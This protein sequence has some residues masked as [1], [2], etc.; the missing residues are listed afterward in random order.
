[1]TSRTFPPEASVDSRIGYDTATARDP[2]TLEYVAVTI[3]SIVVPSDSVAVAVNCAAAPT[4]GAVPVMVTELT[5]LAAVGVLAPHAVLSKARP[6]NRT[7]TANR[8]IMAILPTAS[9]ATHDWS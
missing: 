6:R 8:F 1:V 5:V 2:A 3:A 7:A 9:L 4:S